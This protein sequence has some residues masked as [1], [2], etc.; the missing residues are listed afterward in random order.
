LYGKVWPALT[1]KAKT[2]KPKRTEL[3]LHSPPQYRTPQGS[4]KTLLS[5][6]LK[7][8][9]T[10]DFSG[11]AVEPEDARM[12]LA[13]KSAADFAPEHVYHAFKAKQDQIRSHEFDHTRFQLNILRWLV[14]G[15][16]PFLEVE[17]KALQCAFEE[18]CADAQL[19]SR[20]SYYRLLFKVLELERQKLRALLQKHNGLFN[21]TCDCWSDTEQEEFIGEI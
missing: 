10:E 17:S 3:T 19:K 9:L 15:Q 11:H 4:T 20:G 21:F 16:Q 14:L 18:C 1:E 12:F 5:H 8:H 6:I 2:V 7:H 13:T